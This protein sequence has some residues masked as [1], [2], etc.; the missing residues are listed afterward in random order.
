MNS[1]LRALGALLLVPGLLL[2]QVRIGDLVSHEGVTPVRLVGY[3]LVVGLDGSGDRSF[4]NASGSPQTVRTVA[5]LLRRFNIE[6]PAERMRLR[7][8]A[9]VLVTAEISPYLRTGG[10]FDLHVASIGD[11]TSLRGGVLWMTPLVTDQDQPPIGTAQGAVAVSGD[12]RVR[13]ATRAGSSGRVLD[14]GVLEVALPI[15][16]RLPVPRL[17]L[18]TPDLSV[19]ARIQAVIDTA[20]GAGTARV[21]DPGSIRLN[22]PATMADTM[23]FLAAID[24]LPV[25]VVAAAQIV[26]DGRTGMVVVGGEVPIRAATVSVRGITLRIGGSGDLASGDGVVALPSGASV[27]DVAAGLHAAGVPPADVAALFEG[28]RASQALSARVTVR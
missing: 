4:G 9:A 20:F 19:A 22:Y 8:V 12:P 15:V 25:E 6:V 16:P 23:M 3:G 21:E 5:N 26:I 10:R 13:A 11:A 24:T 27:G 7:N 14:G 17:V 2:G 18:R 28:L 1:I